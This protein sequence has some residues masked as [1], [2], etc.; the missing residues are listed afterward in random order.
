MLHFISLSCL[1]WQT[2][3]LP[4]HSAGS[5]QFR[6]QTNFDLFSFLPRAHW[7]CWPPPNSSPVSL[8]FSPLP[9]A[10]FGIN[11]RVWTFIY[12]P[13]W[14]SYLPEVLSYLQAT[15]FLYSCRGGVRPLKKAATKASLHLHMQHSS[16]L[17]FQSLSPPL[18]WDHWPHSL[19]LPLM[20]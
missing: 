3:V 14:L 19:S 2:V 6:T 11:L 16:S 5:L 7:I 15:F 1:Q 8:S 13:G 4:W 10:P 17:A 9:P 20:W 18:G 12:L